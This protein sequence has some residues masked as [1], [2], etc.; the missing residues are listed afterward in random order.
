MTYKKISPKELH[1]RLQSEEKLV[2]LDVRS[3]EKFNEFHIKESSNLPKTV[4]FQLGEEEGTPLSLPKG[5]EIIVT[6]TTGN[7]AAKC[8][9]I[10][11]DHNYRVTVLDGGLTAWKAYLGSQE[12]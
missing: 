8:A 2:L 10:L 4:I 9:A 6:C 3:E 12:D 7:S 11:D 1:E 5:Q